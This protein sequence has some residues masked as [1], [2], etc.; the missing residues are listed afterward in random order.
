MQ[1]LTH[2]SFPRLG[3]HSIARG[4]S[5]AFIIHSQF[6]Y[7]ASWSREKGL[8][9]LFSTYLPFIPW[10]GSCNA[11]TILLDQIRLFKSSMGF[12]MLFCLFGLCYCWDCSAYLV[13]RGFVLCVVCRLQTFLFFGSEDFLFPQCA[14]YRANVRNI[15]RSIDLA[16]ESSAVSN[17]TFADQHLCEYNLIK[18]FLYAVRTSLSL[19]YALFL[20]YPQEL[21]IEVGCCSTYSFALGFCI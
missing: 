7:S 4:F 1:N 9:D 18:L 19:L 11:W 17:M 8:R 13:S 6:T 12:L 21:Q 20:S 5:M 14:R 15:D 2:S 10:F 3:S 16:L